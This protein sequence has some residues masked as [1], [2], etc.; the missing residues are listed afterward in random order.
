MLMV[1]RNAARNSRGP[2]TCLVDIF[3]KKGNGI[4]G[5]GSSGTPAKQ[6]SFFRKRRPIQ[7]RS[8][9]VAT[10]SQGSLRA[11]QA[12]TIARL[13]QMKVH[14]LFPTN[15]T[16]ARRKPGMSTLKNWVA[17]WL[18]AVACLALGQEAQEARLMRF[19]DIYKDKVVFM[20]GGGLLL[21][22]TSGGAGRRIPT[23]PG[24]GLF[25]KFSPDGKLDSF[26]RPI[27]GQFQ[28]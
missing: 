17:L 2:L 6:L 4:I 20:Y 9:F 25:P 14:R 27:E 5:D 11:R 13:P 26:T 8:V 24:R 1:A 23:H 16:P 19:P 15:L 7:S 10:C 22:F 18:V 12:D 28:R 3:V 21:G